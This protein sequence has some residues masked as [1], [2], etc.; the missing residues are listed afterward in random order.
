LRALLARYEEEVGLSWCLGDWKALNNPEVIEIDEEIVA[1]V[2]DVDALDEVIDVDALDEE[3]NRDV[4][5]AG[6][7]VP[8]ADHCDHTGCDTRFHRA[9]WGEERERGSDEDDEESS[10][11][12]EDSGESEVDITRYGVPTS[13]GGE[14]KF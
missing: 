14:W 3:V 1:E 13:H 2:I 10:D 11:D 8:E 5:E 9:N 6:P 12:W 4:D 7:D